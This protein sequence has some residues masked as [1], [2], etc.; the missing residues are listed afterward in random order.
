MKRG[1]TLILRGVVLLI[2]LFVLGLCIFALPIGL[3]S[4]ATG[5]YQPVILGLYVAAVPFFY[6][7]YQALILLRLI[8]KNEAFSSGSVK[9]FKVIKYCALIISGMFVAGSPYIYYVADKDDAPG[10]LAMAC[11]IVFASFIIATFC[12]VLQKLVQAAVDLK[13]ENDLTV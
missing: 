1:S 9:S 3:R 2:G 5:Y 4:D 13:A 6:A 10:V 8:D 12:A 11:I 7:L